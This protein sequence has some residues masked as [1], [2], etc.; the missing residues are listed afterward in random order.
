MGLI[1]QK[2]REFLNKKKE[3]PKSE[4]QDDIDTYRRQQRQQM[5]V[6]AIINHE[7]QEF[8]YGRGNEQ[9]D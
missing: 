6:N 3:Q 8:L 5:K 2:I 1:Q 4:I 7:K 9:H